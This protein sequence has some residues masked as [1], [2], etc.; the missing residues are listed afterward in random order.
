MVINNHHCGANTCV[1]VFAKFEDYRQQQHRHPA[2]Q[3]TTLQSHRLSSQPQAGANVRT[4]SRSPP[5]RQRQMLSRSQPTPVDN[6]Y[7]T[8]FDTEH[9]DRSD[10]DDV[11]QDSA[12]GND[13]GAYAQIYNS[14]SVALCLNVAYLL[15]HCSL[16]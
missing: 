11:D 13:A 6:R 16:M 15:A 1:Q 14:M 12:Y 3:A 10:A 4:R 7:P 5:N 8:T 2:D 9:E